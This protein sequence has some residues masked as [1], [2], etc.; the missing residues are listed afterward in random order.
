MEYTV[1]ATRTKTDGKEVIVAELKEKPSMEYMQRLKER[2]LTR[3]L[4]FNE[5]SKFRIVAK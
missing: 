5:T 2:V 3:S 4:E 1:Y